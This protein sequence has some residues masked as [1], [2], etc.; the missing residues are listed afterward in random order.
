MN[1]RQSD[2]KK[3]AFLSRGL[4]P[5]A[6]ILAIASLSFASH[7]TVYTVNTDSDEP[8]NYA[9]GSSACGSP[10]TLRA[11]IRAANANPG[12]DEINI[13]EG[14]NPYLSYGDNDP[15]SIDENAAKLDDL[16]ITDDLTIYGGNSPDSGRNVVSAGG[17]G[18]GLGNRVFH[19]LNGADVTFENIS[20]QNGE[21]TILTKED[22]IIDP[23]AGAGILIEAS[24]VVTLNNVEVTENNITTDSLADFNTVGGGIFVADTATI[25]INDSEITDNKAPSGGGIANAGRADIRRTL[26]DRNDATD[27]NDPTSGSVSG[28]GGGG[29]NNQGGYLSL[30]SSTLSN[31]SSTQLGGGIYFANQ[32]QNNGN[33]ILTN[34]VVYNN[35]SEFGGAGIANFGPLSI[36]NS[37]ITENTSESLITPGSRGNG[38][39]ILNLGLGSLDMVNSTVSHNSGAHSG[40]GIFSSRDINLTNVTIYDNEATPCASDDDD[41]SENSQVGGNQVTLFSSSGS[42]PS[43]VLNNTIIGNGP[44]SNL[45][46]PACAGSTGYTGDIKSQGFNMENSNSCGLKEI[47]EDKMDVVD[48]GLA[49]LDQD[50]NCLEEEKALIGNQKT[51][52]YAARQVNALLDGS[53]AID[54]GTNNTCPLVDQ[55]FMLRDNDC[56]IGAYEYGATEQRATGLVDLKVTITDTPDPVP[57]KNDQQPLS[58]IIVVTNLYENTPATSVTITIKLPASFVFSKVTSSSTSGVEPACKFLTPGVNTMTCEAGTIAGLGRAEIFISGE[59]QVEGTIQASV[60]VNS[61]TPDAFSQNNLNITEDTVV[62]AEAG[63]VANFGVC[64]APSSGGSGGGIL[65]PLTLLFTTLFLLGRRFRAS[66]L[67]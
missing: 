29:I 59:P 5:L 30:A 44:D 47:E 45:S 28:G 38:V 60:N 4:W 26:I 9:N 65:H 1:T 35:H 23:P 40:G 64:G 6:N 27:S 58:Y 37:A 25:I 62:D 20:I 22:K 43:M 67:S 33:I 24:S 7:A 36:N 14:F 57:P 41:C 49:A 13:A 31:N 21:L 16:D 61:G 11:A 2:T 53:P 18:G 51:C 63:C 46:E 42:R 66:A 50:S 56:D 10:C 34:S 19:I 54:S 8:S 15:K 3:R 17:L 12:A 52:I 55:R 32:G 48:L 39:G